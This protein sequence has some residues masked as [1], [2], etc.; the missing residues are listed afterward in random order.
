MRLKYLELHGYKTFAT[1]T[2]FAFDEGITTIVGPNGSG[3]SNIAD[4]VRWVLGEQSYTLLRGKR[5]EDMIFHGSES[6]ARLGMAYVT[7]IFDN[8]SGWLPVDFSEVT[9]TR[10]AYRSGENE[11]LLNGSRVRLKDIVELLAESGLGRRTYMVIGQGLVDAALSLRPEER[12]TLFEEAAGLTLHRT[13]RG[14]AL[15]KLAATETNLLRVQDIIAEIA[16]RLEQLERQAA[17]AQDHAYLSTQLQRLL[18]TWYGYQWHKDSQTLRQAGALVERKGESLSACRGEL[19]SLEKDFANLRQHQRGLRRELE[20]LHGRSSEL[21]RQAEAVQRALAVAEE[22]RRLLDR[23]RDEVLAEVV[24]LQEQAEAQRQLVEQAEAELW[25]LEAAQR[26]AGDRL[27]EARAESQAREEQRAELQMRR[28]AA[29]RRFLQLTTELTDQYTGY[30]RNDEQRATL[31]RQME[32]HRREIVRRRAQI[33]VAHQELVNSQ[34]ALTSLAEEMAVL[35][36]ERAQRQ[37]EVEALLAQEEDLRNRV[38]KIER[39]E[40]QAH[41]RQE[42]L[43]RMH[44]DLS[45]YQAGVRAILQAAHKEGTDG[46][47]SLTGVLGTVASLIQVPRELEKAIE[48]ALAYHLQDIVVQTKTDAEAAIALLQEGQRGRATL[49]LLESLRPPP[50]LENPS[51][52]GVIGLAA[53]LVPVD[54]R[55]S[56]V[57]KTLLNR[58]LVVEDLET[59][60]QLFQQMDGEFQIVTRQGELLHSAGFLAAGTTPGEEGGFLAREREWRGL[61]AALA[62]LGKR[63][64]ELA[65]ALET[66]A[67]HRGE[68]SGQVAA[69]EERLREKAREREAG[70][71]GRAAAQQ[72]DTLLSQEKS[73]HESLVE[74]VSRELSTLDSAQVDLGQAIAELEE[75]L[76]KVEGEVAALQEQLAALDDRL[77]SERL[78][79]QRTAL[80]VIEE[81]LENQKAT[82]QSRR[83]TGERIEAQVAAKQ[84][85]AEELWQESQALSE[86]IARLHQQDIT[87]A[88]EIS[89]VAQRIEPLDREVMALEE[90]QASMESNERQARARLHEEEVAYSQATL[91]LERRQ[92]EMDKLRYQI[93]EELG[94]VELDLGDM[95]GQPPLP[96]RPLVSALPAMEILPEGLEEDIRR[97][98]LQIRRLGPIN[99]N[100]PLE[101]AE[102]LERHLFLKAQAEDLAKAIGDLHEIVAELDELM[103]REFKATFEAVAAEFKTYFTTLFS[104]GNAYLELTDPDNLAETGV[105]IVACPPGKRAQSLALLSGGER[106][107]AA[108]SLIFAFLKAC[109]TPFCIL[110]EVDA[111]LDEANVGRFREALLELSQQIQFIV[112]THNRST[113]EA[114]NTIYGVSLGKDS[115][116]RVVSLKLEEEK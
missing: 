76:R 82:L 116:S 34:A 110:D 96:L 90:A 77:L 38:A 44:E 48:A 101:Y 20:E 84:A 85:R 111:M 63:R 71:V 102:A 78:S 11:Y 75:E 21:H 65:A 97:L 13:K 58:T 23:Q 1:W 95:A 98:R 80:A 42:L 36:R 105:D 86:E 27:A 19:E 24:L 8:T 104:G 16:P 25:R 40:S 107:L 32:D 28:E 74:Q 29:Q 57:V 99:P 100:A 108:A 15:E 91:E 94:L 35:E 64:Q 12:R 49:L 45:G 106:A 70:E 55:L 67:R 4:A 9:L 30:A 54:S 17:Q 37:S 62:E 68:L 51:G 59:A 5:T 69:I 93:E 66:I 39:E 3:K 79:Q 31:I 50:P 43:A 46:Q 83:E 114:A 52:P 115:I 112:I 72:R 61:P 14:E 109:P 10:R 26:E 92:D 60:N 73:W 53:A 7:A 22:R 87:L 6:H 41:M 56:P 2:R 88:Q 18:R 81:S 89:Q 47:P 103:E 33:E 113:I